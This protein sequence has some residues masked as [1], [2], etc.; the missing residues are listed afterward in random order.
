M[1][2]LQ[3]EFSSLRNVSRQ[4]RQKFDAAPQPPAPQPPAQQPLAQTPMHAQRA[5]RAPAATDGALLP[6]LALEVGANEEVSASREASIAPSVRWRADDAPMRYERPAEHTPTDV[7]TLSDDD[8]PETK[9]EL[10][11]RLRSAEGS[12]LEASTRRVHTS[13]AVE[14]RTVLVQF[15]KNPTIVYYDFDA[16]RAA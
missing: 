6:P 5:V 1:A 9:F 7:I 14:P 15:G 3:M 10:M 16:V 8:E 13:T 12:E 4:L 11:K 2:L